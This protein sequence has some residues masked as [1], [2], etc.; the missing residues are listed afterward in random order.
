MLLCW[1]MESSSRYIDG[2]KVFRCI[3][4]V[5]CFAKGSVNGQR[6]LWDDAFGRA[7]RIQNIRPCQRRSF[8]SVGIL[9]LFRA[10]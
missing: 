2:L 6:L 4:D 1:W 8:R 10:R 5:D 9:L 7:I 3:N